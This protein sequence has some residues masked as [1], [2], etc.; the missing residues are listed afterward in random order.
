[1]PK[2]TFLC[3]GE[4][5]LSMNVRVIFTEDILPCDNMVWWNTKKKNILAMIYRLWHNIHILMYTI[6]TLILKLAHTYR[7]DGREMTGYT[8][9][10]SRGPWFTNISRVVFQQIQ[11]KHS[12][13]GA[14]HGQERCQGTEQ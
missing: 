2:I 10:Q 12:A 7:H 9:H 5:T 11:E 4:R 8:T 6:V 13:E 3:S 14:A 1:M